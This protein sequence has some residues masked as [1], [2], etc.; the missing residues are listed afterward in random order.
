MEDDGIM[1][2]HG[3]RQRQGCG[4]RG[5]VR[6][7]EGRGGQPVVAVCAS[8]SQR[9]VGAL[10]ARDFKGI[11]NQYVGDGKVI[12]MEACEEECGTERKYV[13]RRLTPPECERLQGFHDNF[14][15]VP[16][17]GKP[18]EECPDGPRYKALGNS[19]AVPVIEW[20][21]RRIDRAFG[22]DGR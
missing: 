17:R 18:A 13:V 1:Y 16:Y 9:V 19:M 8:N 10:C 6:D 5:L 22:H 20:I 12:C 4:G 3:G 2:L 21:G 7:V 14:T 15:M 11:G